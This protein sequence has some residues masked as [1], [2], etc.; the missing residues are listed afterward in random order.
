[1]D[2]FDMS[3]GTQL[4]QDNTWHQR[5]Q[6]GDEPFLL[7][8]QQFLV[9]LGEIDHLL[10]QVKQSGHWVVE[11]RRGQ[12]ETVVVILSSDVK[13]FTQTEMLQAVTRR[14]V[15][16][17]FDWEGS[18]DKYVTF[19]IASSDSLAFEDGYMYFF[20]DAPGITDEEIPT[21]NL[22]N[23]GDLADELHGM[24]RANITL[25]LPQIEPDRI[26]PSPE[27][28]ARIQA[29]I[30]EL[31]TEGPTNDLN[32]LSR[33]LGAL[34][35]RSTWNYLWAL[36][37]DGTVLWIVFLAHGQ[38][39]NPETDPVARYVALERGSRKYPELAVL[40]P[41]RPEGLTSCDLCG[42]TG[43]VAESS[44]QHLPTL[45]LRCNGLG[46]YNRGH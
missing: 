2:T 3:A 11:F 9:P 1:M 39:A 46:W 15:L 45:C 13:P 36:R 29:W 32:V 43:W 40:V 7:A 26:V 42:G 18:G 38:P 17:L 5:I 35:L 24:V 22:L 28:A 23:T 16:Q 44:A 41:P 37:P 20:P 19:G 4:D 30:D 34:P 21:A 12:K 33:D 10:E 8:K 27:L 25:D 31:P 14:Q 6:L